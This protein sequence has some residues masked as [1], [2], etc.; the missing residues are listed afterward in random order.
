MRALKALG[1]PVAGVDRMVLS[2]QLAVMDLMAL[3]AAMLLPE[4]DLTLAAVLKG[5][6]FGLSE[7]QLFELAHGRSGSLWGALQKA[8]AEQGASMDLRAAFEGLSALRAQADF[9]PPYEFFADLLGRGGG[10]CKLLARLGPEAADAIEEFLN[11]ALLYEREQLPS[12]QGF[13]HWQARGAQEVKRDMEHGGDAVRVMTVHGAKGLQAPIVILPD[14]RQM[15]DGRDSLLWLSDREGKLPLWTVKKDYDGSAAVSARETARRLR[16]E[17]YRRLLYVAMTRAE[18]RLY[19]C[20]W[21]NQTAAPDGCWYNL[22]ASALTEMEGVEA[23][24]LSRAADDGFEGKGW[25]L[26]H[27][28]GGDSESEEAGTD[29]EVA[30]TDASDLP[31]WARRMAPEEPHPPRPLMPSRPSGPS[32]A[33][34]SPLGAGDGQQFRR[35]RTIHRLLQH[36]PTVPAAQRP[37]LARQLAQAE[38]GPGP[39]QDLEAL[40]AESLGVLED[41]L[42]HELFGP[43]SQAE[44]PVIGLVS[45]RAGAQVISGQIDRLLV[46][47]DKVRIVDFKTNRPVPRDQNEVPPTYLRQLAAYAAV[48]KTI[49]PEKSVECLLLWT[50]VPQ[51]MQISDALIAEYAP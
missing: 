50:D 18:D 25:R 35:G 8:A 33:L 10:R 23:L 24:T 43:E 16:E 39:Q 13:L 45:G 21:D 26:S 14:T 9:V 30:A 29:I 42:C 7:D 22:V 11:Q 6:F 37:K 28:G 20:G 27:A 15:P 17:E 2:D 47:G 3:G 41:P 12:L 1:V 46:S 38:F 34:R 31:D 4:D 40:V 36:L 5:P 49:Y 51:L 48:L 32:P 44:V 19:L